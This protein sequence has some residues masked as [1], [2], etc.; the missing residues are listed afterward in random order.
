MND[1]VYYH[2]L[3]RSSEARLCWGN[4]IKKMEKGDL[5][6]IKKGAANNL[7]GFL[8]NSAWEYEKETRITIRFSNPVKDRKEF[9]LRMNGFDPCHDILKVRFS[10]FTNKTKGEILDY[11]RGKTDSY[12]HA[13]LNLNLNPSYFYNRISN[14]NVE[15]FRKEHK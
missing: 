5:V 11:V 3:M 7:V 6:N 14:S 15:Y 13:W 12:Y 1:I 9:L 4:I 10:P 8:K 2:G